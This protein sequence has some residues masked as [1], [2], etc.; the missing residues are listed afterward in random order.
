MRFWNARDGQPV[1]GSIT[2][3]ATT[4]P[5]LAFAPDGALFAAGCDDGSVSFWDVATT[6]QVGPTRVLRGRIAGLSFS[7][8]GASLL[9]DD[10]RGYRPP[11]LSPAIAGA[12]RSAGTAAWRQRTGV[13]LDRAGQSGSS[14]QTA[15]R[16]LGS[17]EVDDAAIDRPVRGAA[18]GTRTA[19]GTPRRP[20]TASRRD[21]HLDRLIAARPDDGLFHAR[22]A[23]PGSAAGTAPRGRMPTSTALSRRGPRDRVVDWLAHRAGGPARL[24]RRRGALLFLDRAVASP[25]DD[26]RLHA[27]RAEALDTLGRRADHD[28]DQARAVDL[29]ADIPALMRFGEAGPAPADTTRP[30]PCSTG[31]S[32]RRRAIRSLGMGGADP[33]RR[34]RRRGLS[35]HFAVMRSAVPASL[36]EPEAARLLGRSARSGPAASATTARHWAG[37]QA[38]SA[39]CRGRCLPLGAIS[40]GGRFDPPKDRPGRRPGSRRGRRLPGDGPL[41]LGGDRPGGCA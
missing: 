7:P 12:G 1:L 8:D 22:R 24:G 33:P 11:G 14:T 4:R 23:W 26:W 16:R 32:A 19:P 20:A 36:P 39:S 18:N 13:E 34:R 41:S 2:L 35:P 10:A 29:G 30:L 28:A 17:K 25:P 27:L 40:R 15:W 37:R 3:P 5:G 6:R 9:A 21:W 38:H 31:P